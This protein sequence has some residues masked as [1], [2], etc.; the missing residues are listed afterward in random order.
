MDGSGKRLLKY[1]EL[2]PCLLGGG[3]WLNHPLIDL[4]A[5]IEDLRVCIQCKC[6]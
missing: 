5:S 6:F 4:V 3:L 2:V 1:M